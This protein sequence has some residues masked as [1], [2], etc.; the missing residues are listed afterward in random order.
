MFNSLKNQKIKEGVVSVFDIGSASV[1]GALVL[2]SE[3]KKPKILY[4]TRK[5]MS[6]Q[7]SLDI[8]KFTTSM[9][10]S[11]AETVSDLEKVGF[12]HLNFLKV[13]NKGIRECFCF[14]SSPWNVSYTKIIEVNKENPFTVSSEL[15]DSFVRKE[16]E[17][18]LNSELDILDKNNGAE[19]MDRKIIQFK[20]NGYKVN[21]PYRKK[22]NSAEV[23]LFLSVANKNIL[24]K[25]EN[26]IGKSFHLEKLHVHSFTLAGFLSLRDLFDGEDDFIFLDVSGEVT[27]IS[28]VKD[29]V[30]RETQTFPLGRNSFIRKI[31]KEFNNTYGLSVSM[32][33]SLQSGELDE[34]TKTKLNNSLLEV[35]KQWSDFLERGML[36]LSDGS[37][38]PKNIF[39][40]ADDDIGKL[41][42]EL[43]E[44]EK[45][46]K[47][48][49]PDYNK[50]A[51]PI[52][53]NSQKIDDFCNF[54]GNKDK[55]VFL[56]IE[57]LFINRLFGN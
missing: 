9:L 43:V 56:G 13:K 57:T 47:L 20:L 45:F 17:D 54:G 14:F 39:I 26:A 32:I 15:I 51:N 35:K 28:F 22:I 21:N 31:I 25:V 53:I 52:L 48:V 7:D 5:Q 19:L 23:S 37:I 24:D 12:S 55:D 11:L 10:L 46:V 41:L 30:I 29:G 36:E 4:S 38:L 1:G 44:E 40:L 50:V 2:L 33:K 8:K 42:K 49:F 16:E 3:G 27:D 6:F 18:F 34:V